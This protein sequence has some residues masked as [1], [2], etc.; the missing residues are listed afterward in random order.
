[1]KWIPIT[2]SNVNSLKEGE[3]IKFH[4]GYEWDTCKLTN[5]WIERGYIATGVHKKPLIL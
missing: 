3:E 2:S 5:F 4:N 1:M